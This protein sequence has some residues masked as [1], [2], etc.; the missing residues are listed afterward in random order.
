MDRA[1]TGQSPVVLVVED[2]NLLRISAM[3]MLEEAGFEVIPASNADE[4]IRILYRLQNSMNRRITVTE[5]AVD[6][7]V[8]FG[9]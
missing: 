7:G 8:A 2:E 1:V 6:R 4:A 3:E 9:I 5:N